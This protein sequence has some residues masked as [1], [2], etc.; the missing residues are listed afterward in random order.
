[1]PRT[2]PTAEVNPAVLKWARESAGVEL[3]AVARRLNVKPETV[4]KWE[5]GIASPT[6][7]TVQRLATLYKRPLAA[8]FLPR[9][10]ADPPLPRDFRILPRRG[11]RR[12]SPEARL[13]IREARRVQS[14]AT[15]LADD[16]DKRGPS[17]VASAKGSTDPEA[18]AADERARL[19]VS[20][21]QQIGWRSAYAALREWRAAI[22][23]QALLTLQLP[24]P[25]EE[26]RGCSF[27]IG[28]IATIVLNSRDAVH[29][30]IFSLLHE[31]AHLLLGASALCIP[32]SGGRP[33]G[34]TGRIEVFCNAFAAALLVPPAAVMEDRGV[35]ARLR[36]G[37]ASLTLLG[38][39]SARFRVS[40]EVVLRR[41]RGLRLISRAELEARIQELEDR[42][43]AQPK[44]RKGGP[45]P[46]RRCVQEKG[47]YFANLVFQA[48][49]R[50]LITYSDVADYLSVRV[51]HVSEVQSLLGG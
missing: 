5:E 11:A 46:A 44:A 48:Q 41:L 10:P 33:R 34:D 27:G 7:G 43:P 23:N 20:V 16:L 18:L 37:R 30:R 1:M 17:I 4:A 51:K 40:R 39:L 31:Y 42:R 35:R 38:Q 6:L 9:P 45:P 32:E 3:E 36:S 19:G 12:L 2:T 13:A 8:L 50:D 14:L 47:E 49:T 28:G 24:M 15:E 22:E 21:E 25:L 29:A 26:L